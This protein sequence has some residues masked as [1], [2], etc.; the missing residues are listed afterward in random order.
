MSE[1]DEEREEAVK[2]T[3]NLLEEWGYAS[4][5]IWFRE[6]HRITDIDKGLLRNVLIYSGSQIS[7]TYS[8][9]TITWSGWNGVDGLLGNEYIRLEGITENTFVMKAF[10]YKAGDVAVDYNWEG[11][12]GGP[13]ASGAGSF[14][15]SVPLG[16][17]AIIG[18]IPTGVENL[19]ID[20]T[21]ENDLDI[22]L[23]DGDAF[24]VGWKA[25]GVNA[26]IYSGSEVTGTYNSVSITWSGW[27]G[28]DGLLGNEYIR[29]NGVT[30]NDFVMK[31]FGYRAGSVQVDYVWGP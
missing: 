31:V 16:D 17:R 27:N 24:V 2:K 26:V 11:T 1:I 3:L 13:A 29:L 21:A 12:G 18:T 7:G 10:G 22:E 4:K 23:W 20:L 8:G 15:K 25:D 5:F 6:L 28:V 14:S 9:V 19:F 30:Q